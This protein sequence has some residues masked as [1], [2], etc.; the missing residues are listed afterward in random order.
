MKAAVLYAPGQAL[1]VEELDLGAPQR[2][3]V[4]VR[5]VASGLC[6]TDLHVLDGTLGAPLPAVLGHEGAGVVEEVGDGVITV[7]PGDHVVL[8]W[9][10]SCGRCLYCLSGR[11]ALC[12]LG[13]RIRS[14][15]RMLDGRSRL[16]RGDQEIFHFLGVSA[17]AEACVVPEAAV[18]RIRRDVPLDRAVLLGCAVLTGVGAVFNAAAPPPGSRVAV[19]GAGG[20]GLNVVQ[21][22]ALL[23][24]STII[25]VDVVPQKLALARQF[26]AT[27]VI[28]A[29]DGD[30]VEAIRDVTG[31]IG[32]DYSF[33]AIGSV[34]VSEQA[35]AAVRKGGMAVLVGLAPQGSTVSFDALALTQQEKT[36][37]GSLYGSARPQ[38]DIP[39]LLDLYMAGRLKLDELVT[40]RYPLTAINDAVAALR[41][42]TVARC[43]IAA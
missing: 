25:A 29:R 18:V 12:D 7:E 23:S 36:I 26:G 43:L 8:L 11:P 10:A 4:R 35:V 31:G 42:G 41:T 34:R 17:F 15:G 16:W 20:V 40:A 39:R 37:R 5:L 21:G 14:T 30:A 9:R 32:V 24:A 33:E 3:E 22:A 28:D 13:L 38:I 2:G 19:F 1:Q 27:H 6:G